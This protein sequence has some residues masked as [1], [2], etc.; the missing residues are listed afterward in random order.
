MSEHDLGNAIRLWCGEHDVECHHIN[1]GRIKLPNGTYF[2]TGVP[3][4]W[5]DLIMLTRKGKVFFVETKYG[6]G[7][8]REDQIK[9]IH[10]LKERNFEVHVVYSMIQFKVLIEDLIKKDYF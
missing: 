2:T 3:A 1:V 5:P 7:K 6:N 4:G 10:N 9:M 8:L